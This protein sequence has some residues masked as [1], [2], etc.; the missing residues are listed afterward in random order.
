MNIRTRHG[1][2]DGGPGVAKAI[3]AHNFNEADLDRLT[4]IIREVG[5][6][7][8]YDDSD[9]D[10]LQQEIVLVDVRNPVAQMIMPA[11]RTRMLGLTAARRNG[12]LRVLNLQGWS[13][14]EKSPL[15]AAIYAFDSVQ[16]NSGSN[17]HGICTRS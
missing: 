17:C 10:R 8:I 13:A 1:A 16:C 2:G 3:I 12:E 15:V 5:N 9:A 6:T 14:E 11:P 4:A 7:Y